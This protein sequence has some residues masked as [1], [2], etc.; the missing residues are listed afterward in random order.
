VSDAQRVTAQQVWHNA[1]AAAATLRARGLRSGD[2]LALL[3]TGS[4]AYLAVVVGAVTSGVVPVPLD[5]SLT[6]AERDPL[7]ADADPALVVTSQAQLLGL[8]DGSSGQAELSAVPLVRPMHYT[9][10]T[11]GRPKGVYSGVLRERSAAAL[12]AD[13]RDFWQI[14]A[15]DRHLVASPLHHSA[16]LRFAVTTLLSGGSVILAGRFDARAW[17]AA[18]RKHRPT[19]AFV[20]PAHLSRVIES[21]PPDTGSFRLLAHAGAACPARVKRATIDAFPPGSVWEFY[22]STEGQ[23]TACSSDEWEARPGTVGRARP[24]RSLRV[25]DDGRLWCTAPEYARFSY[26]RDPERTERAWRGD[27]FTVGDLGRID[28]DGY[29][30]LDGRREDL[31]ISGGVNVYPA[32]VESALAELPGVREAAVFGLP[33]PRWGQRVCAAVIGDVTEPE[34]R[35][36]AAARL[37]PPKRPKAYFGVG[38]LPRTSTGKVRR[39]DLPA[40][41][42]VTEREAMS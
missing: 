15:S 25:D 33:D 41:V 13:E 35:A 20:V 39:L 3:A 23:F 24:G 34:L 29:V 4:E 40:H 38:D 1:A 8:L 19:T 27:A 5:P 14:D 26:W 16:P 17:S 6:P 11:T 30:F 36:W 28:A 31:V 9:S 42:G 2:R 18:V 21:G 12:F 22:G 10:G 7:L 37:S 32:E